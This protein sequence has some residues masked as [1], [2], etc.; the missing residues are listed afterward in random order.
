[1]N[2]VE[3]AAVEQGTELGKALTHFS[4][5][6]IQAQ[7]SAQDLN[8]A[9]NVTHGCYFNQLNEFFQHA[10]EHHN[11][12]T[13]AMLKSQQELMVVEQELVASNQRL[14]EAIRENTQVRTTN[15]IFF[16]QILV[17]TSRSTLTAEARIELLTQLLNP[18]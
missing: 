12:L 1:L 4:Q 17:I 11:N 2:K 8:T 15:R 5:S 16:D 10:R 6:M 13:N 9:V 3:K 18:Q 14:E 7:N